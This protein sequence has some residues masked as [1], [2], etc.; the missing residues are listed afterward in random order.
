MTCSKRG[1]GRELE[2]KNISGGD[3][4]DDRRSF[5]NLEASKAPRA[6]CYKTSDRSKVGARFAKT[7]TLRSKTSL[8]TSAIKRP[9][10]FYLA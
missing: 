10:L 9:D 2:E 3:V 4:F 1:L 8:V 7:Q 5:V 6:K